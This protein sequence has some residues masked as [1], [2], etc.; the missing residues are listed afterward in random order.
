MGTPKWQRVFLIIILATALIL[1]IWRIEYRTE[2]L[3]D[4]GRA[5]LVA[6]D[7]ARGRFPQLGPTVLTGQHLGPAFYYLA[8]VPFVTGNYNPVLPA[9]LVALLGVGS[10]YLLWVVASVLAGAVPALVAAALWA[11][12]PALVA[13]DQ[14]LWEPNIIPFFIFAWM[15]ALLKRETF[16]GFLAGLCLGILLQLHYPNGIFL[17]LGIPLLLKSKRPYVLAYIL[18]GALVLSPFLVYEISHGFENT[19]GVVRVFSDG[20]GVM[21]GKRAILANLLDY[22]ARVYGRM[23]PVAKGGQSAIAL[24]ISALI[25]LARKDRWT[26]VFGAWVALGLGAFSLYRGVVYDHYLIFLFPLPFLMLAMGIAALKKYPMLQAFIYVMV[27][28]VVAGRLVVFMKPVSEVS[29]IPRLN[30]MSKLAVALTRG[31]S[32]ALALTSSRSFSDLHWRFYLRKAGVVA[33]LPHDP[34]AE[35]LLVVCEQLPCTG[36]KQLFLT[37]AVPLICYEPYCRGIYPKIEMM[38]WEFEEEVLDEWG[39]MLLLRRRTDWLQ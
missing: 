22:A 24:V 38:E 7:M 3:G 11:V 6:M 35:R 4:Q 17:L 36:Y 20:S 14:I 25:L 23:L 29:D 9:V 33:L 30:E 39:S 21:L 2:F 19:G 15:A 28:L 18:G 27:A 8:A 1:R 34:A 12:S 32:F 13:T 10:V 31:E 16:F 37:G 26:I 5:G